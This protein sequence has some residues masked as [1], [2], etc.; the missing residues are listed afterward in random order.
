M[1]QSACK[2]CKKAFV[3]VRKGHFYCSDTC[4]K[5]A[6]KSSKRS[7]NLRKN[8]RKLTLKLS[9]LAASSYGRY[10]V[11]ELKRAC[12]VQV[13]HG[14]THLTLH[15]LADLRRRC[16]ANSGFENGTANWTFELSHIKPVKSGNE[17]GLLHPLNLVIAT[18]EFN[19]RLSKSS[20]LIEGRGLA[21]KRENLE[22]KW[23]VEQGA[24]SLAVLKL[25]RKF[26]GHEFDVWLKEYAVAANQKLKLIAKLKSA[27]VTANNLAKRSHK[28]LLAIDRLMQE[29][30][31]DAVHWTFTK[32]PADSYIS[33]LEELNRFEIDGEIK[34]A[35]LKVKSEED[36]VFYPV[37]WD[38]KF[39][40]EN[41]DQ[42]VEFLVEQAEL[43]L[44]G[45]PFKKAW[46]GVK[47]LD[48]WEHKPRKPDQ[49]YEDD[50]VL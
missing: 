39:R 43:L 33:V 4:R 16:T 25:A 36:S 32:L 5:L 18:K 26:L 24:S 15:A 48:W 3:A 7:E 35:L 27:G 6:H 2:H 8:Q 1:K 38:W 49:V 34:Q 37:G 41:Y 23:N 17:L 47:F 19:R 46:N 12:T 31:A 10:L 11:S 40:G 14:H 28:E 50:S 29:Q 42:Y 44:H 22:E 13:L 45:Q 30:D 20:P 9:K 21:I